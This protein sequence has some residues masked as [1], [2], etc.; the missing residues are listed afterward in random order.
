L[1]LENQGGG[2]WS[3]YEY[4]DDPLGEAILVVD[5]DRGEVPTLLTQARPLEPQ[6]VAALL[7]AVGK[8]YG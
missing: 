1:E 3:Y 4:T 8:V 7:R 5:M 2:I 6:L